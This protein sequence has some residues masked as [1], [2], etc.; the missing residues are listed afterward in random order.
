MPDVCLTPP[1]PP[2]GPIPIPYPNFAKASDTS[3]GSKKVKAG[4][5]EINLKGKSKYKKSNGDEAATKSLGMGVISHNIGGSVKHKVGSFDVKAEGASVVR[6]L[7]LTTGNHINSGNGCLAP[8]TATAN[9]AIPPDPECEALEAKNKQDRETL[10][11]SRTCAGNTNTNFNFDSKTDGVPSMTAASHSKVAIAHSSDKHIVG[12]PATE[13]KKAANPEGKSNA[14][15]PEGDSF[16]YSG[17][18]FKGGHTEARM[19]ET[20]FQNNVGGQVSGTLTMKIDWQPSGGGESCSPCE[21]CHALLCAAAKCGL[22]IYFC[23]KKNKKEK[24]DKDEDCEDNL[25]M[26]DP[27]AREAMKEKNTD[28][29]LRLDG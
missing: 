23:T 16:R 15:C 5:K 12:R 9:P 2:A 1:S 22:E 18:Y 6:L 20:I 17:E 21:Y 8:D 25:D 11:A 19:V 29:M 7:D 24:L 27:E 3:G 14:Q 10:P 4:G 26:T 13:R 28:L